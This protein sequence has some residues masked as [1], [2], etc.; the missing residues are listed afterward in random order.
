MTWYDEL[1]KSA[2]DAADR[3]MQTAK[4]ISGTARLNSQI[5]EEEGRIAAVYQEIG[6]QY[7]ELHPDDY[8]EA[9]ADQIAQIRASKE[10]ITRWQR[11][12]LV[13]KGVNICISCGKEVPAGSAFCNHC[14]VRLPVIETPVPE[15]SVKCESCGAILEKGMLFCTSCG[16]R[17]PQE[18]QEQPAA[19]EETGVPSGAAEEPAAPEESQKP[20]EEPAAAEEPQEPAYRICPACGE[21]LDPDVRFCISCGTP[22]IKQPAAEKAAEPAERICPA[23][24]EKLDP[25]ALFCTEC[26]RKL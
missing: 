13:L 20:A 11:E 23:C 14:G 22:V 16:A 5:S 26:G 21:K 25:K 8:E 24:G 3:T 17:L 19:V 7:V 1:K 15:G 2:N 4:E 12:I 6:K 10:Q 9:F 18:T